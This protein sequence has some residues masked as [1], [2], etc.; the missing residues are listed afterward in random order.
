M[1]DIFTY[2]NIHHRG[3]CSHSRLGTG[4]TLTLSCAV[5]PPAAQPQPDQQD[6]Y[7]TITVPH[8]HGW[9]SRSSQLQHPQRA[10]D[11]D[12]LSPAAVVNM[13]LSS[14]K[15]QDKMTGEARPVTR[16]A[17]AGGPPGWLAT[18]RRHKYNFICNL[19]VAIVAPRLRVIPT[20]RHTD[21]AMGQVPGHCYPDSTSQL[22]ASVAP[23]HTLQPRLHWPEQ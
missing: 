5:L 12:L 1:S 15:A 6:K 21:K 17:A 13:S 20:H 2:F 3:C 18:V 8:H 16:A 19:N 10:D 4:E 7:L 23:L 22:V 9:K 11:N 14:N